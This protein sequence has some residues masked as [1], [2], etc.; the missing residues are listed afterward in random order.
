MSDRYYV[1]CVVT[2]NALAE[3]KNERRTPSVKVALRSM[4]QQEGE[5][6]RTLYADLWLSEAAFEASI[7]T[8]EETLGW[9]GMSIAELNEPVLAGVEVVAVC[10]QEYN[11]NSGKWFEKVLFLNRPGSGGGVARMDEQSAR[12][13]VSKLDGLLARA[14]SNKPRT[15]AAPAPARRPATAP[16][17]Q[18]APTGADDFPGYAPPEAEGF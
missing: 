6:P 2:G 1:P 5:Q 17:R 16:A 13:I 14:R 15:A 4:P 10:E 18:A 7:K 9:T 3:A 8:L 11:Q 12:G